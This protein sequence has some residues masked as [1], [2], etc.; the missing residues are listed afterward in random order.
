M[1]KKK[2]TAVQA[3]V[4]QATQQPNGQG[5]Q[6]DVAYLRTLHLH[7]AI[8]CYAGQMY[9]QVMMSLLNWTNLAT[10]LGIKW[11]C[12]T[13]VNE[14]LITRG[15]NTM[16]AKFLAMPEATHLLFI[17]SDIGF[18]AEHIAMLLNHTKDPDVKLVAGAYPM[19]C[20]PLKWVVNALPNTKPRPDGLVEVSKTGT[21]FMLISREVFDVVKQN[22]RV[23]QYNND[24]GIDPK[25]D[26]Y[27]Y[28]F[29]DCAVI[30]HRY[31]SEDWLFCEMYRNLGGK[32]WVDGR[33]NLRH[34]GTM[35]FGS[36]NQEQI[37]KEITPEVLRRNNIT[38]NIK[39]QSVD[40][41]T[42]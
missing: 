25:F 22:P 30:N 10:Q 19:K 3:A 34:T 42:F 29:W 16:T 31:L 36:E 18:A 14:S 38:S 23:V 41:G 7:I 26:Q 15:R 11:T 5:I 27:M 1:K 37:I 24:L 40:G 6:I 12:E 2:Q 13:L 28:N 20:Y 17:D 9:E 33:I 32:I 8:P 39:L 21:G 4:E 35:T